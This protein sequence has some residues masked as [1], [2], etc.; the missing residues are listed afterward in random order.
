MTR[1]EAYTI[2]E[3]LESAAQYVPETEAYEMAWM[4]PVW[5]AEN[6]YTA[7]KIW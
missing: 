2:R 4:Y 5:T 7:G 6:S 1:E 3:K